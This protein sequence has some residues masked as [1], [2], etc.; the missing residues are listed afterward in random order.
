MSQVAVNPMAGDGHESGDGHGHVPHLAHHFDTPQQQY[1]SAKLGMWVFL[2]TEILM[3][4][5]LFCAYAV[6]RHGH[7]EVF[8]FAHK[9]LNPLLGGINTAVLIASSF[10]M[11]LGVRYSQLGKRVPLMVCL[12]LTLLGGCGFMVIKGIEY[13]TKWEHHLFP[14]YKNVYNAEFKGQAEKPNDLAALEHDTLGAASHGNEKLGKENLAA[15]AAAFGPTTLPANIKEHYPDPLAGTTDEPRIKAPYIDPSGLVPEQQGAQIHHITY[16]EL[17]P[18]DQQRVNAFFSVY[19][20]MT[21]LHG[22]HVLVGMGL[23]TWVLLRARTGEF[24]PTY[25]TPV[26]IV[27][28]YWHLVDLIWIFLFPLLYL[29]H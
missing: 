28:L 20:L 4:G 22:F 29:I 6:Y 11:A 23:I 1:A 5:G 8:E 3:F 26:D 13:K 15:E 9:A 10:T 7:P 12:G 18:L 21:G 27:G 14:G 19:F 24:G 17:N 16:D 25:F 2:G